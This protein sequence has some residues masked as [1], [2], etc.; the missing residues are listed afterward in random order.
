MFP[1]NYWYVGAYSDEVTTRPLGRVLLGEPVVLFRTESGEAAALADRCAHRLLPLSM[2]K[3]TGDVIQCHYHA[4]EF[5]RAGA[6]VRIPG[7]ERIPPKMKVRSYPVVERDGHVFVWMGEAED[8]DPS[9]VPEFFG[10]LFRDGWSAAKVHRHV[11]GH[12]QLVIDNLLDLS[13]LATVHAS[14]VGSMHVADLADVETERDGDRVKVS[15]WTMD[16]PAAEPAEGRRRRHVLHPAQDAHRVSVLDGL[17]PGGLGDFGTPGGR[18]VDV[19]EVGEVEQVVDDELDVGVQ[20]EL[21]VADPQSW[22]VQ[23]AVV[24]NRRRVCLLGITHP[25]PQEAVPF[26]ERVGPNADSGR[27]ARLSGDFRASA[28]AVVLKP[29]VAA[30]DRVAD[31]AAQ[32]QGHPPMGATVLQGDRRSVLRA[33]HDDGLV[34]EGPREELPPQFAREACRVPMVLQKHAPAG[35]GNGP[36]RI[37][38]SRER[39]EPPGS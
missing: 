13:H 25:D 12:Y 16:V 3:V 18:P 35:E 31:K 5:D 17:H 23:Y 6:C 4:L 30:L 14:T 2:G 33:E 15:R 38:H 27:N 36:E 32:R 20:T 21:D 28:R 39:W 9:R 29:V 7:Q 37:P 1:R 11:R 26:H 34:Q 10:M 19:G 24:G 8:A 22:T